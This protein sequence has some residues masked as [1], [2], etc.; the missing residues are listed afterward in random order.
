[1][2][3]DGLTGRLSFDKFGLRR[4]YQLDLLE[5]NLARGLAKVFSAH[6]FSVG[7]VTVSSAS[8][9]WLLVYRWYSI[10]VPRIS[11]T[12]GTRGQNQ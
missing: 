4:Q 8:I 7:R 12:A 5:V 6:V 10:T 1:M 11:V 9:Q 3:T 2:T